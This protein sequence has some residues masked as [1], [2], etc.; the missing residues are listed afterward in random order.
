MKKRTKL[1]IGLIAACAGCCILAACSSDN[2]PY[3]EFAMPTVHYDPN[4]G[5]FASTDYVTMTDAYPVEQAMSGILLIE[6]GDDK[7]GEKVWELSAVSRSGYFLAGW[8][9]E[10]SLRTDEAG[11]P[12][13]EDGNLCSVSHK[14]QG[15]VYSGR[16]NFDTDLFTVS[17]DWQ[18]VEG[19]YT[20]TLYAAWIPE[21]SYE[22]YQETEDGWELYSSYPFNPI[23]LPGD[24]AISLPSLD[25]EG[26]AMQY[27]ASFP[28]ADGKTFV[29]AYTDADKTEAAEDTFYHL[30][31]V[32]LE[33]GVSVNGIT[34][35][36]TTWKDGVW[37]NI[38]TAEQFI[39][40]SRTD[41]C[42]E[43]LADLDFTD[44]TWSAGLARGSFT[45]QI[46]GNGH[47]F[48]NISVMQTEVTQTYGGLFGRIA[49]EAVIKN[50]SFQ[51][52]TYVLASGSRVTPS[53]FGLFAGELA[54]NATVENVSVTGTL[55]IG[56]IYRTAD[57]AT[58]NIGELI[59]NSTSREIDGITYSITVER[60]E[61]GFKDSSVQLEFAV[62]E[63]TGQVEIK[64]R[65][66]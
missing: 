35:C 5:Q 66:G 6:P 51:N 7:R 61:Q 14:D 4:G 53:N 31:E 64:I 40:N 24:L 18:Y 3:N 55:Q 21:F 46:V 43:I 42:Y 37:F 12:L 15:Y 65:E 27:S 44:L 19:E 49:A 20:M 52:V 62:D 11:N 10:R 34:K 50:V 54:L 30:G 22:F 13:D 2:S 26:V 36:Y 8:Y 41:G 16:W 25:A 56:N 32:D 29:A 39:A 57:Y 63:T 23:N 9:R 1:I 38:S 33:H 59:G 58:Y 28:Q 60:Y 48:S 17:S 47:S 45:G